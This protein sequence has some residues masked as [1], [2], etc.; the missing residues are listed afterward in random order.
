MDIRWTRGRFISDGYYHPFPSPSAMPCRFLSLDDAYCTVQYCT[1]L[2]LYLLV[3]YILCILVYR[4]GVLGCLVPRSTST[5]HSLNISISSIYC[6][7]Q[8]IPLTLVLGILL[9]ITL[10]RRTVAAATMNGPLSTSWGCVRCCFFHNLATA[11]TLFQ[12][13]KFSM[14][15]H[16]WVW[17]IRAFLGSLRG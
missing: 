11:Q 14:K 1:A 5:T 17:Q 16:K 13:R 4:Q 2:Y 7:V 8:P 3:L 9:G 6:T 15:H 10:T 12:D